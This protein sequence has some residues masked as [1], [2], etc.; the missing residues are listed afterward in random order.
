M[1]RPSITYVY[2]GEIERGTGQPGYAWHPG[3][4]EEV[5]GGALFPWLT[6]AECQREARARGAIARFLDNRRRPQP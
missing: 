6:R 1:K 4:S 2:R 5:T 3:Y